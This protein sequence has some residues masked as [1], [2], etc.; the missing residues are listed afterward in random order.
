MQ[1]AEHACG[2]DDTSFAIGFPKKERSGVIQ[3]RGTESE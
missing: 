1:A 2:T 3:A